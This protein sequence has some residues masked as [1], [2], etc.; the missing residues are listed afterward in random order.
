MAT[1]T[2]IPASPA[3]ATATPARAGGRPS[4][5]R[6]TALWGAALA[7][8]VLAGGAA[9]WWMM[10]PSRPDPK[11]DPVTVAK[12]VATEDFEELPEE[13]KRDYMAALRRNPQPL[14][15]ARAMGHLTEREYK[16]AKLNVWLERKL[17]RMDDYFDRP[18]GKARELYLDGLVRRKQAKAKAGGAKPAAVAEAGSS[19][20]ATTASAAI[21][22]TPVESGGT[23]DA[24]ADRGGE[25]EGE[26]DEKEFLKDRMTQWPVEQRTRWEEFDDAMDARADRA[27]R[28]S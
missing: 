22:A 28:G 14:E 10:S 23:E 25:D 24:G 26:L 7:V 17:D 20:D 5:S 16:I 19:P 2:P 8:V 12:F 15:D 21:A 27:R 9:A 18:P 3:A 6:R 13:Q 1:H 4:G 11:G